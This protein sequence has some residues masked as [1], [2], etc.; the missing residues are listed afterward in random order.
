[1]HPHA[2]Y[3]AKLSIF[4]HSSGLPVILPPQKSL[5]PL[6]RK[7]FTTSLMTWQAVEST[8][9]TGVLGSG[10]WI[11]VRPGTQGQWDGPN[12]YH[13]LLVPVKV[14]FGRNLASSSSS[15]FLHLDHVP[16]PGKEDVRQIKSG[17]EMQPSW[18]CL[19][20]KYCFLFFSD[21]LLQII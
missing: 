2:Y 21:R 11:H 9:I 16:N 4:H 7:S 14:R 3:L 5:V 20:A 8:E 13:P 17:N 18:S 10:R 1:M 6:V 15:I 19:L 12:G